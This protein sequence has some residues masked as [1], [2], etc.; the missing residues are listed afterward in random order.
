[1][2]LSCILSAVMIFFLILEVISQLDRKR[3][4]EEIGNFDE[5]L[6]I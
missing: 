6:W 4:I 3:I 2:E 1:M 5:N